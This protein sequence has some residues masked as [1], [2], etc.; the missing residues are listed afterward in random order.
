MTHMNTETT[1]N[2][3]WAFIS[4]SIVRGTTCMGGGGG[5]SEIEGE[6]EGEREK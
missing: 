3:M 5:G 6:G 1:Q 4:V 2:A